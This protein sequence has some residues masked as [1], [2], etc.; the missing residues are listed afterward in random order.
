MLD[1]A[2]VISFADQH[3]SVVSASHGRLN[4]YK[5]GLELLRHV[6][7]RWDKGKFGKE[8]EGCDDIQVKRN[9]DQELGLGRDKLFEVRRLHND[10]TFIDTFL[11][12]E[13]VV[14]Q[15]L[16]NFEYNPATNY[17]EI[18]SRDFK[19]IKEKLLFQLTNFGQPF[20]SV[21][22]GNYKNRGELYLRHDHGG[23]DLKLDYAYDTLRNLQRIWTRPVHI[24]TVVKR[25]P[26]IITFDGQDFTETRL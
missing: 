5:L 21:E 24:E 9:W 4:P 8:Y 12:P 7:D 1:D 22:D 19:Q 6:E 25:Q 14:E 15:K 18:V 16:F 17:Y 3:A 23:I 13:F 10:V 26:K 11:T 2:E 20:I